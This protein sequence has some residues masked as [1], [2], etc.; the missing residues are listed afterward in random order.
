MLWIKI[1]LTPLFLKFEIWSPYHHGN[2]QIGLVALL[3]VKCTWW[4]FNKLIL[5]KIDF[6]L[7]SPFSSF[8]FFLSFFSPPSYLEFSL[9]LVTAKLA[10]AMRMTIM[11]T[12]TG[13]GCQECRYRT[14]PI[15]A[16]LHWPHHKSKRTNKSPTCWQLPFNQN[17][18]QTLITTSCET[19][20]PNQL[21]S[22]KPSIGGL[23]ATLDVIMHCGR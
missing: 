12:S 3:L 17:T 5:L 13:V 21:Q 11:K 4:H 1:K 6:S 10:L 19:Y 23:R 22:T 9:K 2:D 20:T 15:L 7:V 18:N 8:L 14:R 16:I